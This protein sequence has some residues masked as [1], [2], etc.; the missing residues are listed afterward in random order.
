MKKKRR[1][2]LMYVVDKYWSDGEQ[3]LLAPQSTVCKNVFV[4]SRGRPYEVGMLNP[5]IQTTQISYI[6]H[7]LC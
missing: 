2:H 1:E 3:A 4:Y 7:L 6:M 5:R